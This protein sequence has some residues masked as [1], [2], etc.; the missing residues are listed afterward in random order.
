MFYGKDE[1]KFILRCKDTKAYNVIRELAEE[2]VAKGY[3]RP[4]HGKIQKTVFC[5]RFLLDM[6]ICDK[7]YEKY[8]ERLK[9]EEL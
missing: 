7:E 4:P 6:D 8:K 5:E 2:L 1:V 9:T 3:S